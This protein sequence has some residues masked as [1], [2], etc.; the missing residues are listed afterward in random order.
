MRKKK[1]LSVLLA[2]CMVLSC[3]PGAVYV[4]AAEIL[5]NGTCGDNLTWTLDSEGTLTITGTGA[6]SDSC[7][8]FQNNSNITSVVIKE[9]VTSIGYGAFIN[10]V[11]LTTVTLP[12]SLTEIGNASF[13]GC[14]KLASIAIPGGVTTIGDSVFYDCHF[15]PASRFRT[16]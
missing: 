11:D 6:M 16:L 12:K 3:R 1:F 4:A 15:L 14:N 10:C 7:Y 13:Y 9:G 5:Y 8:E 2:L